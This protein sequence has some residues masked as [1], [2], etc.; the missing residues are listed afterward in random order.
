MFVTFQTADAVA[1]ELNNAPA[2]TFSQ[3]FSAI[4]KTI[5][6]HTLKE[7]ATLKVSVVP[8]AV[9]IE[10]A[11]RSRDLYIVSVDVGIQKKIGTD[12]E[13][14]VAG[15]SRL[16]GEI[17]E[18]LTR[19]PLADLPALQWSKTQNTLIYDLETLETMR[20]FLSVVTLTYKGVTC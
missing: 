11:S 15:L 14:E 4:R 18:Y 9:E 13:V 7:L 8:K 3:E 10:K 16:V 12:T 17:V 6:I 5:P 2:E 19:R 1:G 20:V